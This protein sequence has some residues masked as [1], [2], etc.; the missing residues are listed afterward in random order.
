MSNT[1]LSHM[2]KWFTSNKLVLNLYKNNII[3]LLT[4]KLPQYDLIIGYDEKY[5]EDSINTK[6]LGLQIDNHLNCENHIDLMIS[7][8]SRACYAIRPMSHISSTDTLKSIYSVYFHS[9]MKNGLIFLG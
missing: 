2:S 5:I 3:E 4:N 1:F 8:L 6:F 7:M 9:I